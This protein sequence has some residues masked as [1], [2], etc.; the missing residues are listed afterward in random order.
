MDMTRLER[1]LNDLKG[2]F[3]AAGEEYKETRNK[4]LTDDL[5]AL[6]DA[7]NVIELHLFDKKITVITDSLG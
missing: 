7:I 5:N 6:T 1:V 3:F 2:E 4:A